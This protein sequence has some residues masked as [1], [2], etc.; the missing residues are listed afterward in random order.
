MKDGP[1]SGLTFYGMSHT[2]GPLCKDL[3][4]GIGHA[5]FWSDASGILGS[6]G[7]TIG[8]VAQYNQVIWPTHLGEQPGG[9]YCGRFAFSQAARIVQVDADPGR[10]QLEVACLQFLPQLIGIGGHE[11]PIAVSCISS[12]TRAYPPRSP[13]TFSMTP[14]ET[15]ALPTRICAFVIVLYSCSLDGRPQGPIHFKEE[16]IWLCHPERSEGSLFGERSFAP[17][18]MTILNRFRLTRKTSSLKCIAHRGCH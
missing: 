13:S 2:I 3:P 8:V 12:S 15:G 14:H 9:A 18:R 6:H 11:P 1:Q 16:T 4:L 7:I 10:Q 5:M 17:L